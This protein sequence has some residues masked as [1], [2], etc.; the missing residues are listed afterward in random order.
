M[1][2]AEALSDIAPP[3]P[4]E[5]ARENVEGFVARHFSLR[6]TLRLH[7]AALGWDLLRAPANV[8]LAPL[9]ILSRLAQPLLR[10][11]GLR[12]AAAW[13]AKRPLVL[14]TALSARISALIR[15]ELLAPL[16]DVEALEA[17]LAAY[18]ESRGAM[19]ELT[20]QIGTLGTGAVLFKSLTP[21]ML[22][23]APAVALGFAQSAAIAA[24]PLG[25]ALGSGWYALFPASAPGGLTLGVMLGFAALGALLTTFAGVVAD[26]VQTALGLHQRR[27]RRLIGALE[28][29]AK[30]FS[31]KEPYIARIGDAADLATTV[32][33]AFRS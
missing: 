1:A 24:F 3:D 10:A 21:G 7:R 32:A 2:T 23:F 13:L 26:P 18:S 27:L 29:R 6:G 20:T 33:R 31:P 19:A 15:T 30:G 17:H 16:S 22:S 4:F 14:R 9:Q 28:G 12:G 5:A 25:A 8:A 11:V